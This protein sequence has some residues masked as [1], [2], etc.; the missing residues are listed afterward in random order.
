MNKKGL[1]RIEAR[2][3][4]KEN[5]LEIEGKITKLMKD[6]ASDSNTLDLLREKLEEI[7]KILRDY[8]EEVNEKL[9]EDN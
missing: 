7:D 9:G 1:I 2:Y 5:S 4:I 6:M 3:N 8:L